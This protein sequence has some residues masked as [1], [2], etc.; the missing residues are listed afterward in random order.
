MAKPLK[1]MQL[2]PRVWGKAVRH[3]GRWLVAQPRDQQHCPIVHASPT[4]TRIN[5]FARTG[6]AAG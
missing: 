5:L 6:G 1:L 2:T 3:G 4:P